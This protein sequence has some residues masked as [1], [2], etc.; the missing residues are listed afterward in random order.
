VLLL[1][2]LVGCAGA[3]LQD[4]NLGEL[5]A[6]QTD[7][8]DLQPLQ[9]IQQVQTPQL[10]ELNEEMRSFV[11][12]YVLSAR[13]DRQRLNLLH[14]ALTSR[15]LAAI[16][17]DPDAD[18]TAIDAFDN[19]RANCLSY[20]HLFISMAR[21]AGLDAR[22]HSLELRPEWRRHGQ[23]VSLGRH[24]N[25]LVTLRRR[26]QYV[27]DI[28]PVALADVAERAVLSDREAFALYHNNLA[29]NQLLGEQVVGAYR[30]SVKALQL[31]PATD[32]L[33]VNL[34]AIYRRAGQDL[35]AEQSYLRAL[36]LNSASA[37]AMNNL[38]VLYSAQ[39]DRERAS[40]WEKEV[41]RHRR[42]NPFY[43]MNLGTKAER[44]GELEVALQHYLHAI[45]LHEEDSDFYFRVAK[46]Y[47]EMQQPEESMRYL[48][49]AIDRSRLVREREEYEVFLR[50][51]SSNSV[52]AL[53]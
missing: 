19:R 18:G 23:R 49:M 9:A 13:S 27:V 51:L 50:R 3:T 44:A 12:R 26:E 40:H 47:L 53:D 8:V 21:Y 33:W 35:A 29:M 10:L 11:D 28:D 37:S 31:S 7:G 38:Y 42:R 25:V 36:D 46:L 52:A 43:Y 22:Y 5:A 14:R 39:G 6:L 20:A 16:E 41:S 17:Y 32:F 48:R 2:L 15:G 1:P 24:V 45:E 30:Q 34:G 4:A